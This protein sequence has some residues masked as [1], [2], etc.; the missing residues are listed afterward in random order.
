MLWHS[1]SDFLR[2]LLGN[3]LSNAIEYTPEEGQIR[4]A[5]SEEVISI[6]NTPHGLA[7]ED[8]EH[9][10]QRFWRQDKARQSN[11]HAG[12]GLS[13]AATCAQVLEFELNAGLEGKW[14]VFS[15][16]KRGPA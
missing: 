6:S 12:L 14:L 10:F 1:D 7:A 5:A 13:L 8:L 11:A 4:I 15:V 16:Q 3:L 9:L 2:H